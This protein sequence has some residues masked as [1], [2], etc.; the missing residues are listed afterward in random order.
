MAGICLL[1]KKTDKN[2]IKQ[3]FLTEQY[4]VTGLK[5]D[6]QY[7]KH[8]IRIALRVTEGIKTQDLR[9]FGNLRLISKLTGDIAQ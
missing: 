7:N 5:L 6:I 4:L 2:C 3:C 1:A 9:K 8:S